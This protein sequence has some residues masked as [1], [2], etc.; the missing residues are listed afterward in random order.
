VKKNS[1]MRECDGQKQERNQV[2]P[3]GMDYQKK[4]WGTEAKI[5]STAQFITSTN[6]RI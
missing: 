6:L 2:W 5:R 3:E 1:R 4:L